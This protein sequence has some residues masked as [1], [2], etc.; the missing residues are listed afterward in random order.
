MKLKD[1]PYDDDFYWKG[2][3]YRQFVKPKKAKGAFKVTCYQP[4]MGKYIQMPS[5]RDVK[6]II[7]SK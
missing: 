2:D 5:G 6:P 7:R 4:P 3:R 1:V